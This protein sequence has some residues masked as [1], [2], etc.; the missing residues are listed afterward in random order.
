MSYIKKF[1][2]LH[3]TNYKP[4]NF[5][6]EENVA[7]KY[8]ENFSSLPCKSKYDDAMDHDEKM[9]FR[10]IING[11]FL[12]GDP[13]GKLLLREGTPREMEITCITKRKRNR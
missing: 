9:N 13:E 10:K 8:L 11:L 12:R 5:L 2:L 4:Q 3:P 1:Y 7:D 6:D